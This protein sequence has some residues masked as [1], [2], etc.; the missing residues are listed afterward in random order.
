MKLSDRKRL[1]MAGERSSAGFIGRYLAW[2]R[3]E[4]EEGPVA[5][6]SLEADVAEVFGTDAGLRVLFLMEKSV[7]FSSVPDGSDDRALR[8]K[9]AVSNFVLEI[10]RY[11]T[12][13]RKRNPP[14]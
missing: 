12:H 7:L 3:S 4:G 13:G 2:M 8:E 10:R 11:V 9:N 5:A 14:R 1:R 6:E